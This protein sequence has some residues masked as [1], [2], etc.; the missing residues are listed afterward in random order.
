MIIKCPECGHQ[1]SDRAPFCP[2]CGVEISGHVVKCSECGEVHLL[3]DVTCPNCH[4]SLSQ[5]GAS[6]SVSAEAQPTVGSRPAAEPQPV[7][8]PLPP[9]QEHPRMQPQRKAEVLPEAVV[10]RPEPEEEAPSSKPSQAPAEKKSYTALIIAFLI[11]AIVCAVMLYVYR[12]AQTSNEQKQYEIAMK[13][14]DP[15]ILQTYLETYRGFNAEHA[16]EAQ[17]LL[18]RL[19]NGGGK[20]TKVVTEQ[21]APDTTDAEDWAKAQEENT[22]SAYAAYISKHPEGQ[23]RTQA[24]DIIKQNT[25]ATIVTPEDETRAKTAIRKMLQ[26]INGHNA[27][28]LEALLS[29]TLTY[30]GQ[31][32]RT[33]QAAIDYMEHLYNKVSRLNWYLDQG[34]PRV[35]KGSDQTLTVLYPARLSQNLESGQNAQ[36]NF[37]IHATVNPE[38]IITSLK[39]T[40]LAAP[41]SE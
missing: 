27:S 16:A 39:F 30:D 28:Q 40:R 14:N 20:T 11:A 24:E 32:G 8:E 26:A 33:P 37:N 36:N 12:D 19:A 29:P 15:A 1:V 6:D 3:S 23:Y 35:E 4:H 22:D 13:S 2:S 25:R 18:D 31:E 38:G 21:P 5:T 41:K 10:V 17:K 9:V 7:V 34:N